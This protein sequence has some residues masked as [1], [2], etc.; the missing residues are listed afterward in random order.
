MSNDMIRNHVCCMGQSETTQSPHFEPVNMLKEKGFWKYTAPE[1]ITAYR[2]PPPQ[3]HISLWSALFEVPQECPLAQDNN[4]ISVWVAKRWIHK[5]D[6]RDWN[7]ILW[8]LTQR[9]PLHIHSLRL[10]DAGN[11]PRRNCATA[12]HDRW[13]LYP[14]SLPPSDPEAIYSCQQPRI[15]DVPAAHRAAAEP[16]FLQK[17]LC[18]FIRF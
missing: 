1:C 6:C 11:F 4:H 5:L 7:I 12:R 13:L 10:T 18:C 17:Y 3:P 15:S 2:P 16:H 9:A 8:E 14:K